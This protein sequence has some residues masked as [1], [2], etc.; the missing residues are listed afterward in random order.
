MLAVKGERKLSEA[1]PAGYPSLAPELGVYTFLISETSPDSEVFAS[2]N[3]IDV[4]LS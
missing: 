2:P 4:R 3:S 1:I